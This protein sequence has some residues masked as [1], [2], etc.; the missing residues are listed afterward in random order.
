VAGIL[1]TMGEQLDRAYIDR[2]IRQLALDEE[3]A[4]ALNASV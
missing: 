4:A 2:W 1:A 3:W